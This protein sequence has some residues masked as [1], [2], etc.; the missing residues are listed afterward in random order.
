MKTDISRADLPSDPLEFARSAAGFWHTSLSPLQG[1]SLAQTIANAGV[2][3]KP[4]IVRAVVDGGETTWQAAPE[5]ITLRRAMPTRAAHELSKMMQ[6]TVASGSAYK[7]FHTASGAP[8]LPHIRVAGKTGTLARHEDERHY[9]WFVGFAPADK[10]E[11]AVAALVVNTPNW[12]IK[13]PQLA[14]EV[15]RAYFARHDAPGVT[16]P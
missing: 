13:G 16:L 6:Q 9:T 12:L 1:A 14:R 7:S 4:R 5:P 10:P 11:V 8:Y 15:L 2:T 3:Y